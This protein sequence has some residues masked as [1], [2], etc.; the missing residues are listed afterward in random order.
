VY[1]DLSHF[2][3]NN[4][5]NVIQF[6]KHI[7]LND[8]VAESFQFLQFMIDVINQ[9]VVRIEMNSLNVYGHNRRIFKLWKN[10]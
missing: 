1:S 4:V 7:Y 3:F 9:F 6:Q 2:V 5:Y 8:T 10:K